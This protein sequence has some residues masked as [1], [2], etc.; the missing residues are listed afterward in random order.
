MTIGVAVLGSTGSIGTSTLRVLERQQDRFHVVALT[1]FGAYDLLQAQAE[2]TGAAYGGLVEGGRIP[3]GARR[4]AV[5][6]G[7]EC[8]IEAATHPGASIVLNAVVGAAGAGLAG[9][10]PRGRVSSGR[11]SM[12]AAPAIGRT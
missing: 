2:R 1:A 3:A 5:A 7:P 6:S 10:A 4:Q 11:A 9:S 8:L 12:G